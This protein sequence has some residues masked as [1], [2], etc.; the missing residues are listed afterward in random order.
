[1]QLLS[2]G[3]CVY[4]LRVYVSARTVYL[5]KENYTKVL[6]KCLPMSHLTLQWSLHYCCL[7]Y[8]FLKI[9]WWEL[10]YAKGILCKLEKNW[11]GR[12]L[13]RNTRVLQYG[14][15]ACEVSNHREHY[16]VNLDL[17]MTL[18]TWCVLV[19][20]QQKGM[21]CWLCTWF[22]VCLIQCRCTRS[23]NCFNIPRRELLAGQC[24]I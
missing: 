5:W 3:C 11:K 23:S 1:V 6:S 17:Q 15:A 16:W 21:V 24:W 4:A 10:F 20:Y 7:L 2:H 22:L 19:N 18:R 9:G 8:R 13:E 14:D 12:K